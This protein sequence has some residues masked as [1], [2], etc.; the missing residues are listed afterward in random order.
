MIKSDVTSA[1][2]RPGP[3]EVPGK[4]GALLVGEAHR[5]RLPPRFT[6]SLERCAALGLTSLA[7]DELSVLSEKR[8]SPLPR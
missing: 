1:G 4:G 7:T 2:L 5:P 6:V 3:I 8:Q